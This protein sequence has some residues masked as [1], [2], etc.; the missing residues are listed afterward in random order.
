MRRHRWGWRIAVTSPVVIGLGLVGASTALASGSSS[1]PSSTPSP[2]PTQGLLGGVTGA[3]CQTVKTLPS[4]GAILP[5]PV[6]SVVGSVGSTVGSTVGSVT[7]G[8]SSGS[9]GGTSSGSTGSGSTGSGSTSGHPKSGGSKQHSP[10]TVPALAA[11]GATGPSAGV[12]S[13]LGVPAWLVRGGLGPLPS[14]T[15]PLSFP[16]VHPG[17]KSVAQEIRSVSGGRAV[18]SLWLI[19]AVGVACLV[20]VAGGLGRFEGRRRVRRIPS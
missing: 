12:L 1:S 8:G 13:S 4:P 5:S 19:F 10:A 20:G 17:G 7:S 15:V 16:V 6:A 18:S 3:V 14:T 11:A 2:C 9:A